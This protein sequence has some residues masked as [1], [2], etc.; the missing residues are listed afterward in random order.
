MNMRLTKAIAAAAVLTASIGTAHAADLY[1]P[2]PAE[3]APVY[4]PPPFTWTGFYV[5][6]QAGYA[7]GSNDLTAPGFPADL[8]PDGFVG[9]A[10]AG[11]NYQW[12]W[13][14]LG[15]EGDIEYSGI[16]GE[17]TL[18]GVNFKSEGNW[19]GSIRARLG[20]AVDRLLIY[21][22]GGWA[23]ADFDYRAA[24]GLVAR[25]S[26]THNGWTLGA[27]AEYAI[28]DNVTARVEYRY[29]DF[30]DK[31][32]NLGGVPFS[33]DPDFHTVRLGVSYKF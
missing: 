21:G 7:F 5:G 23:F 22:T 26:A 14:V 8:D 27:G 9:G 31:T 12:N 17:D 13:L 4:V 30:N 18:P 6:V 20:Y 24:G 3:P 2:P 11:Y 33:S 28:T 19:Q 1:T 15:L 10:H 32:I 25:D 16:E 29:T